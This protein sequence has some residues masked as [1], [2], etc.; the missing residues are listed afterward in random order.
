MTKPRAL[1]IA[2]HPDDIE[3][4]M[5]GTMLHLGEAGFELHY[6]NVANGCCGS[7]TENRSATIATRRLESIESADRFPATYHESLCNDL[8]VFY[9]LERLQQLASVIREV[10]PTVVLTHSLTDY[11]E[12]HMITA[13]LVVTATFAIGMPNFPVRPIRPN[14]T[15]DVAIYHAQPYTNRCPLGHEV[16]PS[17]YVD[18]TKFGTDK[19]EMLACHKS[20]RN[21]LDV[22]QG[23]DS[24]LIT[25]QELDSEVGQWSGKFELAEGWRQHLSTGFGPRDWDPLRTSI[26]ASSIVY[27]NKPSG[28]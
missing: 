27:R 2:A 23:I 3:F 28:S 12:D 24:Y 4:L 10:A 19:L 7:M 22:S 9:E 21:W 16:H 26:P 6:M 25:S 13:R 18:V 1:A 5:A 15:K 17:V 11:M 8:E 14:V 20:Q